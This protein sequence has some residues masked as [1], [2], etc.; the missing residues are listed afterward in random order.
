M[1]KQVFITKKKICVNSFVTITNKF[2]IYCLHFT[3][4]VNL[5]TTCVST[6]SRINRVDIFVH[7][8][9]HFNNKVKEHSIVLQ[10][11]TSLVLNY[12]H[13]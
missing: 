6:L 3:P 2:L 13:H 5:R 9:I 7:K 10:G 12:L 11:G 4:P 1:K 8:K